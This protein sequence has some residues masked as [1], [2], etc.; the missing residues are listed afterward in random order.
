MT[1]LPLSLDT[2]EVAS[3]CSADWEKMAGTDRVRHCSRCQL[4]VYRLSNMP[5]LPIFRIAPPLAVNRRD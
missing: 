5:R 2:I 4:N 1:N 3:P